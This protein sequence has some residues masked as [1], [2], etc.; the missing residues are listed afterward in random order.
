M[1]DGPIIRQ[2]AS[3]WSRTTIT[4]VE[5]SSWV[6]HTFANQFGRFHSKSTTVYLLPRLTCLLLPY[7]YAFVDSRLLIVPSPTLLFQPQW[8]SVRAKTRRH[9][10]P[11]KRRHTKDQHNQIR[12]RGHLLG[13]RLHV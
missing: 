2:V 4:R 10:P 6:S 8:I 11:L 1:S 5:P 3:T 9:H 13:E 7:S 12:I